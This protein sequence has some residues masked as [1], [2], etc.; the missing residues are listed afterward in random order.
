MNIRRSKCLTLVVMVALLTLAVLP[1]ASAGAMSITN[2][3][4]D[5][6]AID[7]YIEQEMREQHRSRQRE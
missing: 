3:P 6:A 2:S 1:A 5:F 7:H 4:L